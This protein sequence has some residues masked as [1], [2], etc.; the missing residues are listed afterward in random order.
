MSFIAAEAPF[1]DTPKDLNT[2]S[3]PAQRAAKEDWGEGCERQ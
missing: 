1:D 3:L 2:A